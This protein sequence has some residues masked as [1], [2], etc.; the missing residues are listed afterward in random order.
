MTAENNTGAEASENAKKMN[1]KME[2]KAAQ[3]QETGGISISVEAIESEADKILDEARIKSNDILLKAREEANKIA[4]SGLAL[5]EAE[6]E[7]ENLIKA[8]QEE[9]KRR[10]DKSKAEASRIKTAL[11]GKEDSIVKQL[12]EMVTGAGSR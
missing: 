6:A 12:I 7:K 5:N 1:V 11:G 9:A 2:T 10:L 3:S 4:N 8:A